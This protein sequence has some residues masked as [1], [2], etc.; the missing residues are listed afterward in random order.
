M[1]RGG[2]NRGQ[3]R[4]PGSVNVLTGQ[5][6]EI[7]IGVNR[8]LRIDFYLTAGRTSYIHQ[9]LKRFVNS[10]LSRMITQ[11]SASKST[12]NRGSTEVVTQ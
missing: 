12:N 3:G 10:S 7:V 4:K 1:P 8:L 6:R 5:T 9:A 2:P 11:A